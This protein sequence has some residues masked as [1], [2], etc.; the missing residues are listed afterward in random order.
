[1]KKGTPKKQ[2]TVKHIS[3]AKHVI[4]HSKSLGQIKGGSVVVED[5]L[6]F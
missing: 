2:L 5:I 4:I 6:G 3:A 1:M